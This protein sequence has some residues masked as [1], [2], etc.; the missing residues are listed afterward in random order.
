MDIAVLSSR[1]A[2]LTAGLALAYG[3]S[4]AFRD[5]STI[6]ASVVSTRALTPAV[7]FGL[8]ALFE[9]LGAS[10]LGSRIAG[11]LAQMMSRA[12]GPSP[13]EVAHVLAAGVGAALLW[14]L[15]AAW[16][17]WPM[18]SSQALVGALTG[19]SW[20]AWGMDRVFDQRLLTV[21]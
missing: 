6:V 19:A 18:S 11:T 14:G 21:F 17:G 3:F 8:C 1:W 9:F 7:A 4:N 10:L 15:V 13:V 12:G 2:I 16:R 20:I 5:A